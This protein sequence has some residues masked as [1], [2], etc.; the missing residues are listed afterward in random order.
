MSKKE[1]IVIITEGEKT[2]KEIIEN[3]QKTFFNENEKESQILLLCF[4]TNIYQLWQQLKKDNFDTDIIEVLIER[5]E[6]IDEIFKEID[7]KC[8]SQKYLLFDYDGHDEQ[9]L[10]KNIGDDV[11]QEMLDNFDNETENGKLYISYPMVE[12]I[13]HLKKNILCSE[14]CY[15]KGKENIHYKNIASNNTNLPELKNYNKQIWNRILIYGIKKANCLINNNF[16][17]PNYENYRKEMNQSNIFQYQLK[18]Y[19]NEK[20]DIAVLSGFPFFL[21]DYFGENL[22]ITINEDNYIKYNDKCNIKLNLNEQ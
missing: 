12:A 11:I 9:A 18:K 3:L 17:K 7:K 6:K 1:Y 8:I 15:V 14:I 19:V 13:K 20:N 10:N 22:Y 16:I 21:I 2:E 5:D 4:K